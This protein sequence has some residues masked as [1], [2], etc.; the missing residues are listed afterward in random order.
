MTFFRA[1]FTIIIPRFFTTLP[2][3]VWV[4]FCT[5]FCWVFILLW[6]FNTPS[7]DSN[8]VLSSYFTTLND[9]YN[10]GFSNFNLLNSSFVLMS[11]SSFLFDSKIFRSNFLSQTSNLF[12]S[13][14]VITHVLY[15]LII[16]V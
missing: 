9:S 15:A 11:N 8:N 7:D 3:V 5:V 14:L 12:S 13:V 4:V 16:W 10:I 6:S 2:T 1:F